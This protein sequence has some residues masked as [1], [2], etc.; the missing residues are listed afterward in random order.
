[1]NRLPG[2]RRST[3][4]SQVE[5]RPIPGWEGLYEVSED[6]RVRSIDREVLHPR[7]GVHHRKGRLLKPS[8]DHK[9]YIQYGLSKNGKTKSVTVHQLVAKAFLEGE[10][11]VRHLDGDRENNHYTNLA[12]GTYQENTIDS[13]NHGT[14]YKASKTSCANGHPYTDETTIYVNGGRWRKCR[15]CVNEQTARWR[16]NRKERERCAVPIAEDRSPTALRPTAKSAGVAGRTSGDTRT[17]VRRRKQ[18]RVGR[19]S[20]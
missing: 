3:D 16:R 1:M 10:G 2:T 12:Y 5:W 15:V 14:H 4:E 6:G 9:G 18:E 17:T 20:R 19:E 8:K 13:V 11:I 7:G